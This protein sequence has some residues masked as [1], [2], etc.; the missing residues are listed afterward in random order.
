MKSK[1]SVFILLFFPKV[2]FNKTI[3]V[4]FISLNSINSFNNFIKCSFKILLFI[5]IL[6]INKLIII[7][8]STSFK[9]CPFSL[10]TLYN[11]SK[12]SNKFLTQVGFKFPFN[13]TPMIFNIISK[14]SKY[15]PTLT[16][17]SICSFISFKAVTI[18]LKSS[19]KIFL[20]KSSQNKFLLCSLIFALNVESFAI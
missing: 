20:L 15:I 11:T 17:F 12:N 10:I 4:L 2:L 1:I 18:F 9:E 5:D 19:L 16:F 8:N 7:F 6:S 3:A 14:F 13:L